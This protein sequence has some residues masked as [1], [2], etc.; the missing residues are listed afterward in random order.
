[1]LQLE[2]LHFEDLNTKE[3][4]MNVPYGNEIRRCEESLKQLKKIED[5][6]EEYGIRQTAPQTY[7]NLDKITKHIAGDKQMALSHLF[8]DIESEIK[9]K[10]KFIVDQ[11]KTIEGAV[12]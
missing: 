11:N 1:M 5:I 2:Y 8:Y 10:A 12:S 6:C 7:Q 4:P 3:L 9:R